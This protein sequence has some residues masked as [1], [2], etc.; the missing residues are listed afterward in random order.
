M[1]FKHISKKYLEE[2]QAQNCGKERNEHKVRKLPFLRVLPAFENKPDAQKIVGDNSAGGGKNITQ[3][4]VDPVKIG[5]LRKQLRK[6]NTK[7]LERPDL[8]NSTQC[9]CND[10]EENLSLL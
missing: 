3:R 10:E 4:K 8:D 6:I 7:Y 5:L 2:G 1:L 9:T